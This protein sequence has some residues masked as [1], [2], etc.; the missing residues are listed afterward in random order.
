MIYYSKSRQSYNWLLTSERFECNCF[1]LN[2]VRLRLWSRINAVTSAEFRIEST[3]LPLKD[4]NPDPNV[5]QGTPRWGRVSHVP[6]ITH[7]RHWV[8]GGQ[9]GQVHGEHFKSHIQQLR[10]AQCSLYNL[11][12]FLTPVHAHLIGMLLK[13]FVLF[14]D[15]KTQV[16][17][18]PL[19]RLLFKRTNR[20]DPDHPA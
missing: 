1:E 15:R 5:T 12:T 9:V 7:P 10:A 2:C 6:S 4:F 18:R 11:L 17:P 14:Y 20:R 3:Q 8:L 19:E 16:N 13:L